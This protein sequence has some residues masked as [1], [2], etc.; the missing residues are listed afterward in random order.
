MK[1]YS[2]TAEIEY[3]IAVEDDDDEFYA[4]EEAWRDV[5]YDTDPDIIV[6]REIKTLKELPSG[7]DGMCIPYGAGDGNTR[8]QDLLKDE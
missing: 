6:G 2:V 5:K 1:F 4:A 8:L 3:V 7:W